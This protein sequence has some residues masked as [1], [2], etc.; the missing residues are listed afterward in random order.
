[1]TPI[2]EESRGGKNTISHKKE[3]TPV[4]LSK[5]VQGDEP[6]ILDGFPKT[7]S[8]KKKLSGGKGGRLVGDITK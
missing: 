5:R 2:V 6:S 8:S 3:G 4:R 1:M 7:V